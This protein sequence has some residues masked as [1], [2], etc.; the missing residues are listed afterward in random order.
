MYADYYSEPRQKYVFFIV[1][2]LV[3]VSLSIAV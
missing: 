2:D 1:V 3:R